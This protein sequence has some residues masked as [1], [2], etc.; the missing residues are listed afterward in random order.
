LGNDEK[1]NLSKYGNLDDSHFIG[2]WLTAIRTS[3]AIATSVNSINP[4]ELRASIPLGG[5]I[6]VVIFNSTSFNALLIVW[7]KSASDM[8]GGALKKCNTL[9][10]Y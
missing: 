9:D 3:T 4:D 10:G 5:N 2:Q 6:L 1:H 8:F 7:D